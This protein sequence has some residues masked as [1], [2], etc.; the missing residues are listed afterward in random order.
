MQPLE[1]TPLHPAR[2]PTLRSGEEVER[3]SDAENRRSASLF[4]QDLRDP[5][6]LRRTEADP[7]DVRTSASDAGRGRAELPLVQGAERGGLGPDDLRSGP[8]AAEVATEMLDGGRS[9]AEEVVAK[10]AVDASLAQES[11]RVGTGQPLRAVPEQAEREDDAHSV[12]DV[13]PAVEEIPVRGIAPRHRERMGCA[14]VDDVAG[15]A[16]PEAIDL[17]HERLRREEGEAHAAHL[18]AF[19]CPARA[20]AAR[21][22][23]RVRALGKRGRPLLAEPQHL[24]LSAG[25]GA[26]LPARRGQR[27][28]STHGA[29]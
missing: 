29:T 18:R 1:P 4:P 6:L 5:V 25:A 21:R 23:P 20:G 8:E 7:E 24:A 15:S 14:E 17:R 2:C 22:S 12:G 9:S 10:A 27:A 16:A 13:E 26:P 28:F 3:G 11:E 19:G